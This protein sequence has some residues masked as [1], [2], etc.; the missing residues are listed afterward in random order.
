MDSTRLETVVNRGDSLSSADPLAR[1]RALVPL[2]AAHGPEM[3]RRMELTPE[4]VAEP[5]DKTAADPLCVCFIGRPN[6]GKS[7]LSNRLLRSDR[8][9]ETVCGLANEC[10]LPHH[11]AC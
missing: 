7:S 8:L 5:A 3:D 11:S 1:A 4:V 6:V 9:I 10:P 2:L